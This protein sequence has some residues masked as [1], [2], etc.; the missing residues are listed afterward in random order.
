MNLIM[1]EHNI[2]RTLSILGFEKMLR[3]LQNWKPDYS[4]VLCRFI[5][6]QALSEA[7]SGIF[8]SSVTNTWQ[9]SLAQKRYN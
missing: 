6:D 5:S 9:V 2:R 8:F 3:A 7:N 4:K 1:L